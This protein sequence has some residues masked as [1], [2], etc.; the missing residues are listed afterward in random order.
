MGAQALGRHQ[1]DPTPQKIFKEEGEVHETV[2][3]V[4]I[5]HKLNEYVYVAGR[6]MLPGEERPEQAKSLDAQGRQAFPSAPKSLHHF[7]FALDRIVHNVNTLLHE[8]ASCNSILPRLILVLLCQ[9]YR[10]ANRSGR[11]LGTAGWLAVMSLYPIPRRARRQSGHQ[12]SQERLSMPAWTRRSTT[13]ASAFG[14]STGQKH[15]NPRERQTSAVRRRYPVASTAL[16]GRRFELMQ[17][18][19]EALGEVREIPI[20]CKNG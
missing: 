19:R 8:C 6:G 15:P 9:R 1:L 20:A 18:D 7:R 10:C 3:S 14:R 4:F 17:Y 2:K 12:Q 13:A 5:R 16:F 11:Q